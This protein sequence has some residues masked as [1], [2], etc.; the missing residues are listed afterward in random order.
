MP[1][2]FVWVEN[3]AGLKNIP[4]WDY[5]VASWS[6]VFCK[7]HHHGSECASQ[8]TASAIRY[9]AY[10]HTFRRRLSSQCLRC[11]GHLAH[12]A[13]APAVEK[14]QTWKNEWRRSS[15]FASGLRLFGTR[16]SH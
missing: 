7:R 5:P 12:A 6:H 16:L 1:F 4:R 3:A 11:R 8:Q 10:G 15:V 2:Y 13:A 9:I 14:T